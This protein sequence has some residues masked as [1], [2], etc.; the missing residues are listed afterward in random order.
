MLRAIPAALVFFL[1]L[2]FNIVS[3]PVEM[4]FRFLETITDHED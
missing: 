4:A 1:I 3:V 2:M